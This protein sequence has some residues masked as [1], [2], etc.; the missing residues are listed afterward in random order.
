MNIRKR[1][2]WP[3][4]LAIAILTIIFGVVGNILH[5]AGVR[6]SAP[7]LEDWI[8]GFA[9]SGVI[10]YAIHGI[11]FWQQLRDLKAQIERLR[12]EIKVG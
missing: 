7:E 8:F 9:M 2:L 10:V 5:L 11:W 12:R 4:L 6:E 1:R 3:W